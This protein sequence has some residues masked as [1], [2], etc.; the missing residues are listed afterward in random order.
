MIR[1]RFTHMLL[2]IFE[3]MISIEVNINITESFKKLISH[4]LAIINC[5]FLLKTIPRR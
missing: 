1:N 5:S 4:T 2:S 3:K